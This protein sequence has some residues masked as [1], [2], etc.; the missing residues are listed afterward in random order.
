VRLVEGLGVSGRLTRIEAAVDAR[1]GF[2][3]IVGFGRN[4]GECESVPLRTSV[5][6][7]DQGRAAVDRSMPPKKRTNSDQLFSR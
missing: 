6:L 2:P 4:S 7:Q 5:R 3:D 1:F